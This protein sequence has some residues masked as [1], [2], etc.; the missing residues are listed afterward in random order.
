MRMLLF[1]LAL[2]VAFS[3]SSYAENDQDLTAEELYTKSI[4]YLKDDN[5]DPAIDLLIEAVDKNPQFVLAWNALGLAYMSKD[6]YADDAIDA[7]TESLTLDPN[8]ADAYA[9][10]GIIY[11][12]T[13]DSALAEEYLNKALTLDPA[14]VRANFG[15]GWV[16]LWQKQNGKGAEEA[17]KR[18][19]SVDPSN[20]MAQY[21]LGM[22]YLSQ[23][24]RAMALKSI[25]TLR[26]MHRDDLAANLESA[27]RPQV[28]TTE[29][30]GYSEQASSGEFDLGSL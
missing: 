9:N 29:S 11:S 25:S 21:G 2:I 22:A 17:F 7:F 24:N 14:N 15:A 4:E 5:A 16:D 12:S 8:Q 30:S 19:L 20:A 3:Q 28:Q 27:I 13:R 1:V 6:G 10:L 26:F 23:D 18:V